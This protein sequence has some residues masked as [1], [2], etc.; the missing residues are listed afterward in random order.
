M[1]GWEVF[2]LPEHHVFHYRPTSSAGGKWQGLFREGLM[3][4]SFGSH[5]LFQLFKCA[6]R[7]A[8][9]PPVVGSLVRL[10]GYLCWNLA[11]RK[12]VIGPEQVAFLRRE[13]LAKVR[14]VM[15]P[16]R[17]KAPSQ[18]KAAPAGNP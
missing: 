7:I 9:P 15:L 13:Q 17:R 3:D 6:R 8:G 10:W 14:G 4:A 1:A 16:F 2:A 18:T 11:G 12:P 5:A